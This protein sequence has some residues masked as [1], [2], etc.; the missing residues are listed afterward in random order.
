MPM[1]RICDIQ[2][3]DYEWVAKFIHDIRNLCG[4]TEEAFETNKVLILSPVMRELIRDAAR[5]LD[6]KIDKVINRLCVD[7][8]GKPLNEDE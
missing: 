6:K 2:D 5:R 3:G 7:N 4:M 1:Q 8:A